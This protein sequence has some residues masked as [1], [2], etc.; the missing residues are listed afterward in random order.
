VHALLEHREET[1]LHGRG[2]VPDCIA[3]STPGDRL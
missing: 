1:P 3:D 2:D